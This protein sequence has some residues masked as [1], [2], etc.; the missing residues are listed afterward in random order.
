VEKPKAIK[1]RRK[2]PRKNGGSTPARALG[3]SGNFSDEILLHAGKKIMEKKVR[4]E[5]RG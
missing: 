4:R 5:S 1:S 3:N 2:K